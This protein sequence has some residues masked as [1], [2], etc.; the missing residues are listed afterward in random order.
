[1]AVA[2]P[3]CSQQRLA[4]LEGGCPRRRIL[5]GHS[6]KT[7]IPRPKI[8]HP[9]LTAHAQSLLQICDGFPSAADQ[10]MH[11]AAECQSFRFEARGAD[12]AREM[13]GRFGAFHRF[14]EFH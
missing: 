12:L 10:P 3:I 7:E 1:M 5:G 8:G 6:H 14:I 13:K 2:D 4:F 9:G 11:I